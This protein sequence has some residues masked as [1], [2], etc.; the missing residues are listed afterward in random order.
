MQSVVEKSMQFP[1]LKQSIQQALSL[2]ED[3]ETPIKAISNA[4]AQDGVLAS[5][6]LKLA[7]SPF[8]GVSKQ[9]VSISEASVLLGRVSLKNVILS[10]AINDKIVNTENIPF[11]CQALWEHSLLTGCIARELA[12][13]IDLNKE[14]AL[15]IGIL[16]KIGK[17]ILGWADPERYQQVI[18]FQNEFEEPDYVAE[19]KLLLHDHAE[20]GHKVL[21]R[22][23]VPE[24][25]A[26]TI[27][28]Y[29]EQ[30]DNA[31]DK[32]AALLAL[33]SLVAEFQLKQEMDSLF[34]H[35][36]FKTL[37]AY[38]GISQEQSTQAVER[39]I[40]ARELYRIS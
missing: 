9:V 40:E 33:S 22:W 27:G 30:L 10:L 31:N 21:L 1:P 6:V 28:K 13:S 36:S 3:L 7:N 19:K 25:I 37:S 26:N 17:L 12:S 24:E 35:S 8:Y 11:D 23:Q 16:H 15:T 38:L 32:P 2:I 4:I 5:T 34:T 14:S 29:T 18:T 39:A 20:I